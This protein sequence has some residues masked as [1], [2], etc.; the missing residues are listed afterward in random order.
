MTQQS[1]GTELVAVIREIAED[2]YESLGSGHNEKVYDE[3][4]QVGLRLKHIEYESQR[5]LEVKYRGHYVGE[6]YADL[7]VRNTGNQPSLVLELKTVEKVGP[8]EEQQLRN[9]MKALGLDQ[10]LLINFQAP[11]KKDTELQIRPV[12]PKKKQDA[13]ET[14]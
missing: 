10:G 4:M 3:A 11:G 7:V 8:K 1:K 9:Y 5:V 13:S 6:G 2:V 14:A 12:S